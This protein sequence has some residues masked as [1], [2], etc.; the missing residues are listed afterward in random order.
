MFD[1]AQDRRGAL[2]IAHPGHE[3]RVYQW[4]KLARPTVFVLTDGSGRSGKSR[5][6]Q[7]TRILEQAGGRPGNVYGRLTDAEL[8]AAIIGSRI[9]TFIGLASDLAGA[10]RDEAIDYVVGDALEG[11]N[12]AHDLCRYITNAAVLML[13]R[14]GRL[15]DNFEVLMVGRESDHR[16]LS[17]D[18]G[19]QIDVGPDV[20]EEKI[21]LARAYTELETDVQRI[22]ANEGIESLKTER[23]RLNS[24]EANVLPIPP[25][26]EI[27]GQRQVAAGF[28]AEA[29]TY[30]QHMRPIVEALSDWHTNPRA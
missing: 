1:A 25:F 24:A 21:E 17:G 16:H 7:T 22:I 26:Y 15:L 11:Y 28:Y 13:E 12:P 19:M 6:Y 29:I 3:L 2:V 27:H 18:E 8:Y 10:L 5:I 20:L 14:E 9:Q 23:L 30:E 4:L